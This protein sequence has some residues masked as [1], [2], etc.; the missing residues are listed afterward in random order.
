LKK[1]FNCA[2]EIEKRNSDETDKMKNFFIVWCA[3]DEPKIIRRN[4]KHS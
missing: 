1:L 4:L 3:F 2:F